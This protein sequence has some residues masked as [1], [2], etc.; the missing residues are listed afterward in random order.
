MRGLQKK[1]IIEL[2]LT[3]SSILIPTIIFF[4]SVPE[5]ITPTTISIFVG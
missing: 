5:K 2:I 1:N 3:I 4:I